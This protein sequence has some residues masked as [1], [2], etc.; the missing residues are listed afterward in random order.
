MH[1]IVAQTQRKA[2]QEHEIALQQREAAYQTALEEKEAAHQIALAEKEAAHA[3]ILQEKTEEHRLEIEALNQ[4][5][6]NLEVL[7]TE[8]GLAIKK[9][10][11][12]L[13]KTQD[14][15]RQL[16]EKTA[17][18]GDDGEVEAAKKNLKERRLC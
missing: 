4:N 13:E 1:M 9:L 15:L 6:A 2:N 11:G 14:A 12:S 18:P 3:I 17:M 16:K 5:Y 8:R 10:K 7:T